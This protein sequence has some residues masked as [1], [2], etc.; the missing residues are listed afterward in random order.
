VLNT[1]WSGGPYG[2]GKRMNLTYTRAMIT[3]A[4]NGELEKVPYRPDPVF[5]ILIPE[6]VTGVPAEILTPRNTWEDPEAY[7]KTAHSLAE[8]FSQNFEKFVDVSADIRSAGPS[9]T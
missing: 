4:L 1:V 3:A 7:D 9:L 2:V 6:A 8:S 5:G